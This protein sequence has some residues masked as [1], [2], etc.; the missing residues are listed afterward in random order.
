MFAPALG[1]CSS[2]SGLPWALAHGLIVPCPTC[3]MPLQ[4]HHADPG[5]EASDGG[6]TD[7]DTQSEVAAVV[8]TH[9]GGYAPAHQQQYGSRDL[10][11]PYES[12]PGLSPVITMTPSV[13]LQ[14]A[15]AVGTAAHGASQ[16]NPCLSHA[17]QLPTCRSWSLIAGSGGIQKILH[18]VCPSF[19]MRLAATH[20]EP[21]W[22]VR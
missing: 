14:Q 12:P 22:L 1:V 18:P 16:V 4:I 11:D 10:E 19:P 8:E 7:P 3:C 9:S 21:A 5:S 20:L 15:A 6:S 17:V 2:T 13:Q